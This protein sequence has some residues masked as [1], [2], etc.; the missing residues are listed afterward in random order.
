MIN[1]FAGFN[2]NLMEDDDIIKYWIT[3]GPLSDL[4]FCGKDLI[5]SPPIFFIGGRGCGKTMILKFMSNEIQLKKSIDDKIS[6]ENFYEN[7][8]FIGIYCRFD[9]PSL[10]IFQK[11]NLQEV[12]WETIFKHYLEIIICKEY[13]QMLKNFK[14]YNYLDISPDAYTKLCLELIKYIFYDYYKDYNDFSLDFIIENLESLSK[15]IFKFINNAPFVNNPKFE[16]N[17]IFQSGYL[18]F[19]VPKIIE[20]YISLFQ[21]KKFIILFDEYE[22]AS[23]QQQLIINTLIKHVKPPVTFLIGSRFH[24]IKTYDTMNNDEFLLEDADYRTISF[25]DV[26]SN[27]QYIKFIRD[28][29]NKRLEKTEGFSNDNLVNIEKI[30]GYFSPEDEAKKIVYGI[31]NEKL[32]LTNSEINEER[33]HVKKLRKLIIDKAKNIDPIIVDEIVKDLTCEKNPLIDML[34]IV[35]INRNKYTLSDLREKTKIFVNNE[36]NHP[37]YNSYELLYNKNKL[38]LVF[39]LL[40]YYPPTQKEYGGFKVFANLSSGLIRNFIELCYQSFKMSFFFSPESLIKDN[41]I[42]FEHQTKAAN[43]RS[44]K[45]FNTIENIPEY[46]NEIKSLVL[47][48]GAIFSSYYYDPRLSEPEVTY[49]NVNKTSLTP[50][51]KN[52]LDKAVQWSVL[53]QKE[54]MKGKKIGDPLLDVYVLNHLLAPKFS[55]SY[56]V[57]GRISQFDPEDL[58]KLIFGTNEQ[59]NIT[60]NKLQKATNDYQQKSLFDS[61]N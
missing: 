18:I 24:G 39:Q 58:K 2:A 36:K 16:S 37:D 12:E 60:I 26:V 51:V 47:S 22:N 50:E 25:E 49:F 56:R 23:K 52:V 40:S 33:K 55:L 11:R 43:I 32:N 30:L 4:I 41:Y 61:W 9:G 21:S 53:Q 28:I 31:W 59:K 6:K 34:N 48:L 54:P 38:A 42:E 5:S 1:P 10:S 45:F 7:L 8:H 44:E 29:A 13:L 14:F 57:R 46:G 17:I 3:P 20:N 27:E 15:N 19:G 35:L